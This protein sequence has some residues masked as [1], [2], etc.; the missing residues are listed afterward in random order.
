MR[1][2][3]IDRIVVTGESSVLP[4]EKGE[5]KPDQ[6]IRGIRGLDAVGR[7]PADGLIRLEALRGLVGVEPELR[8][9]APGELLLRLVIQPVAVLIHRATRDDIPIQEY[10]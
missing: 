5:S 9:E 10:R 7:E 4:E 8:D 3:A 6:H 1:V 2:L